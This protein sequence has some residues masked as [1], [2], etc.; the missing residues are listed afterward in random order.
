LASFAFFVFNELLRDMVWL[1]DSCAISFFATFGGIFLPFAR[2]L[3][4]FIYGFLL[5]KVSYI[6]TDKRI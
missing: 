5:G 1:F 2:I 6:T 4:S 3:L